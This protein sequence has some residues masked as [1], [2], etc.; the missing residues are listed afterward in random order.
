M[1]FTSFL[2]DSSLRSPKLVRLYHE[3]KLKVNPSA[4]RPEARSLLRIDPER[5]FLCP[6]SK[7]GLGAA[8]WV[9]L[10]TLRPNHSTA[11]IVYF[12]LVICFEI[13]QRPLSGGKRFA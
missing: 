6:L 7:A 12:L 9:N 11:L 2:Y 1:T 4:V 10:S 3:Q 5:R 8:E 13:A